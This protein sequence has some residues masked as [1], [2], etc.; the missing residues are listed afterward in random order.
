MYIT[1]ENLRHIW[2]ITLCNMTYLRHCHRLNTQSIKELGRGGW[3]VEEKKTIRY[4]KL[5]ILILGC[6]TRLN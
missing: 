2:E 6:S 5:D 4:P 1:Y 3:S